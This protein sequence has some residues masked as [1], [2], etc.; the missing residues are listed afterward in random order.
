MPRQD[1][2]LTSQAVSVYGDSEAKAY[3]R[4]VSMREVTFTCAICHETVTQL[5][6]PSRTPLYCS[7][8]CKEERRAQRNEERVRKQR[9]KRKREREARSQE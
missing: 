7:D 4:M 3:T 5:R 2:P 1:Q 9:E 6:Y 8:A